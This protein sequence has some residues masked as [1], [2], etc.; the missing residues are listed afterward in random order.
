MEHYSVIT[1][2]HQNLNVDEIGNFVVKSSNKEDLKTALNG[3]K[4]KFNIQE[5]IYLTTCNRVT[6]VLYG[7][8][9]IN[10]VFVQDFFQSIN[11]NLSSERLHSL[12][13]FV[14]VFQGISAINHVYE[15]VASLDSL[16]VGEREIY[17]QFR[18][19]YAEAKEFGLVGDNMRLL[20]KSAVRVAKDVYSKTK[21]GEKPLSIVYLAVQALIAKNPAKDSRIILVGAGETNTLVGKFLTKYN[22]TNITIFNRSLDN[23]AALCDMLGA[24]A[25]HL[26]EL[27]TYDKGF[28]ILIACTASTEAIIDES[29]YTQLAK[30]EVGKIVI[31]L[32]VPRNVDEDVV[33]T[34]KPKYIDI[35]KLR[36]LAEA[37]LEHRKGEIVVAKAIILDKLSE[38]KVQFQHRQIEK[39]FKN[40]PVEIKSIKEKAI[41]E[42]YKDELDLL[43]ENSKNLLMEMLNY[44]EKKCVAVPMKVAKELVS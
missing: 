40:V 8:N 28:D 41:N 3:L 24:K 33:K 5:L 16:V 44:M 11:P 19:A 15:V 20:E 14:N 2:T 12:Q 34:F 17:R 23:A 35:E 22:F 43:D 36:V 7:I 13:N 6:Y 9:D 29:I 42:V 21:I 32:S 18:E 27:K 26:S 10:E 4:Y 31:D 25:F 37:N 30:G 1:V 39:L 38:F